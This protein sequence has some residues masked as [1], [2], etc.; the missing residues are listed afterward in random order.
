[1]ALKHTRN[2]TV[3]VNTSSTVGWLGDAELAAAGSATFFS[4]YQTP[5]KRGTQAQ[6]KGVVNN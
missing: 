5:Q 1:M 6:N 2:Q 3:K 4:A